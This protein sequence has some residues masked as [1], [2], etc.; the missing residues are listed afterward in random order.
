M[1]YDIIK[2]GKEIK[3]IIKKSVI[4]QLQTFEV[5]VYNGGDVTVETKH[6]WKPKE[7]R[8]NIRK[9][10]KDKKEIR[11]LCNQE[12]VRKRTQNTYRIFIHKNKLEYLY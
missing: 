2:D 3:G 4:K 8:K 1:F 11:R 9:L 7:R 6:T 5:A 10:K 12:I